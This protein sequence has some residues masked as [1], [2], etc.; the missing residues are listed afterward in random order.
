MKVDLSKIKELNNSLIEASSLSCQKIKRD[1]EELIKACGEI[2]MS[3]S[4]S[5][6]GWHGR[7]Y[8]KNFEKPQHHE[9][10]SGE[11]GGIHGIP[12]GWHDKEPEEVKKVL[13]KK[14]SEDF[15][16]D[17]LERDATTLQKKAEQTQNE[18][19]IALSAIDLNELPEEKALRLEIEKSKF[20]KGKN[21]FI[22]KYIPKSLMT[23]DSGALM[24]GVCIP[25]HTYY[26]G[27]AQGIIDTCD[28]IEK[29]VQLVDRV[30]RQI[31][32]KPTLAPQKSKNFWNWF[33]PFWLV[34]QLFR[35]LS[36]LIKLA[37]K[38]KIFSTV[39]LIITLLAIDYS[40]AWKNLQTTW[41]WLLNV[42]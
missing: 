15:S 38:H 17:Q 26:L 23:R 25:S 40:L 33:N 18:I 42:F 1:S 5:F 3:W 10:F 7:M 6:A 41:D 21:H 27:L 36:K 11:W 34:W 39:I 29:F 35:L 30:I 28:S 22:N 12:D 20:G 19:N 4:G 24:E 14:V 8:F 16:I 2:E 13:E 9:R 31:E 32:L 37:W